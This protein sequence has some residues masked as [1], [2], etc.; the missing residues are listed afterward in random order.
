MRRVTELTGHWQGGGSCENAYSHNCDAC[1]PGARPALGREEERHGYRQVSVV[2]G[3]SRTQIGTLSTGSDCNSVDVAH[4]GSVLVTSF[5]AANVRRLAIDASADLTNTGEVMAAGGD[6]NNVVAAPNSASGV[7][8]NRTAANI[9]SF[10]V[11]GPDSGRY[12]SDFRFRH[13]RCV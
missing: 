8:I 11:P 13:F 12:A 9:R 7:V 2:D 10:K 1:R 3:A 4:S 5:A 6:P